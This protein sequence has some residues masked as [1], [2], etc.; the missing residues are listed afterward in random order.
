M[1]IPGDPRLTLESHQEED[2][3]VNNF[4]KV[5]GKGRR[6][7]SVE[8]ES[9]PPST[10]RAPPFRELLSLSPL[11]PVYNSINRFNESCHESSLEIYFE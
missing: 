8:E 5:S 10:L 1:L 2:E 4:R 6:F 11:S 9:S 7:D 3:R